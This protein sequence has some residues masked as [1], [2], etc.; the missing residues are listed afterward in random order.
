VPSKPA[1]KAR[2]KKILYR[3][4]LNFVAERYHADPDFIRKLNPGRNLN[5]LK[6]GSTVQVPNVQPFQIETIQ[7]VPDLWFA[8]W[9]RGIRRRRSAFRSGSASPLLCCSTR[10][11]RLT[12][13]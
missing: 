1:E 3:S 10:S 8:S 4:A 2:L 13:M 11:K 7:A 12:R 5:D 9:L 6:K